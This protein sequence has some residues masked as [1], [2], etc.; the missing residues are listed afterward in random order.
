MS[1]TPNLEQGIAALHKHFFFNEFSFSRN[2]FSRPGSTNAELADSIILLDDML[3]IFQLKERHLKTKPSPEKEEKWF[4]N[5]VLSKAKKQIKDTVRYLNEEKEILLE[6]EQGHEFNL[7]KIP[8]NSKH[9]IVV[10]K[11]SAYL[12]QKCLNLKYYNSNDVG[13]IHVF[14]SWDYVEIVE[15]LMTIAEVS[16]YLSFREAMIQR[17]PIPVQEVSEQALLGQYL[18]GRHD[19]DPGEEYGDHLKNLKQDVE[20]WDLTGITHN[21]L[22]RITEP[23]P[24]LLDYY[25]ILQELSK[26]RRYELMSFKERYKLSM[27]AAAED[28]SVLPYRFVVPSSSTGFIFIPLP[29]GAADDRMTSLCAYT[30]LHKYE[31]KL[32]RCV[33]VSFV[34]VGN[35]H[36]DVQW[37]YVEYPWKQDPQTDLF[38]KETYPFRPVTQEIVPRFNFDP[39]S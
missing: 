3:W 37:C 20:K 31:Q 5:K 33:G 24:R 34:S 9:R 32:T 1:S 26:L 21:F 4:N 30:E 17:F 39:K 13:I 16:E 15:T 14:P 19:M 27:E 38:L 22:A 29:R 28:R 10:H 36:Y 18:S 25:K 35:Q 23:G 8:V 2:E 6:N 11:P 7:A 12:P